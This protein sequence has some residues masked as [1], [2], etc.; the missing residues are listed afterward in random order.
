MPAPP[1]PPK[2]L[3]ARPQRRRDSIAFWGQMIA[4]AESEYRARIKLAAVAATHGDDEDRETAINAA[5][6]SRCDIKKHQV[7]LEEAV[8]R[9]RQLE[10]ERKPSNE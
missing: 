8:L 5:A 9:L 4:L 3:D 7:R 2:A 6:D 1:P 10:A